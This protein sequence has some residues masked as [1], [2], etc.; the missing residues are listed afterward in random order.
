MLQIANVYIG[1]MQGGGR[2]TKKQV[3]NQ[4]QGS[5]ESLGLSSAIHNQFQPLS[6]NDLSK[7]S[8]RISPC[9]CYCATNKQFS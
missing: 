5:N 1:D 9:N 7:F 4:A 6:R 3:A 2:K 8:G